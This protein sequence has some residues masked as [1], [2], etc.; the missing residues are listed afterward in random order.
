M[1]I[2]DCMI[3]LMLSV[4]TLPPMVIFDGQRVNPEWSKGEV[5]NTQCRTKCGDQELFFY[6]MT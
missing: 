5:P 1:Q 4:P 6:W 2:T 3:V